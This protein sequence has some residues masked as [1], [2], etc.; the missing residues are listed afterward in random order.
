M[1][2]AKELTKHYGSK[3]A[4]D[5][6]NFTLAPGQVTGFLGP[7]GAGKSTTM[8]MLLGLERP[9]HGEITVQ[10]IPFAQHR[11]PLRVVGAMLDAKS[12][13]PRRTPLR[14]LQG[15][16][17]TQGI[18]RS[19]VHEVIEITGLGS[20]AHTPAG[21]FSLGMAQR[22]GIAAA[23]LGDPH[24]LVLDEPVN[25]LDP[26][27]VRWIR[28][29]VRDYAQRGHTVLISSHL[30]SEMQLTADH[31]LVI[32]RGRIIADAPMV[33][34]LEGSAEAEVRVVCADA[35]KLAELLRAK[36]AR[37]TQGANPHELVLQGT[38]LKTV[39]E[40]ATLHGI[41]LQGLELVQPS[42][43]ETYHRLTQGELQYIASSSP[44]APAPSTNSSIS[45]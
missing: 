21:R 30:M 33:E 25:G 10:G 40:V 45:A 38:T 34:L 8:R 16:A 4:V 35:N 32:A 44:T 24:V 5:R 26:D 11:N 12:V 15:M 3:T 2:T 14:Y 23:L 36:G 20:V 41:S 7:N 17:L 6:V 13:H 28:E 1:I 42:L 27:G 39:G 9:D 19:R 43:E 18:P 22:L 29:L 37:S 31:L